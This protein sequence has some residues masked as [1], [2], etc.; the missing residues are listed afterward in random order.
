M[1]LVQNKLPADI[2][3]SAMPL[4]IWDLGSRISDLKKARNYRLLPINGP[5]K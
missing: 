5:V 3:A 4:S 1:N 2:I